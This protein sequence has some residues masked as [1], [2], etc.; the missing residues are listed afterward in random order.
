M[1]IT[2]L[3]G[4]FSLSEVRDTNVTYIYLS[5]E[6]QDDETEPVHGYQETVRY[7]ADDFSLTA[8]D[9]RQMVADRGDVAWK[10]FQIMD[11]IETITGLSLAMA[12]LP[13]EV[14]T[15]LLWLRLSIFAYAGT[16]QPVIQLR[17]FAAA[18]ALGYW[19][20]DEIPLSLDDPVLTAESLSQTIA[21]RIE[22]YGAL[23]ERFWNLIDELDDE[24]QV[25]EQYV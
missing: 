21:D 7:G 12:S 17:F 18:D 4:R 6:Y 9:I 1:A 19:R 24:I 15:D 11:G 8:D 3:W 2:E 13:E 10:I 5:L 25:W 23:R 20:I 16:Q 22:Q 14:V